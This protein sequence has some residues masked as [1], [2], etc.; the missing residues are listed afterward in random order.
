MEK[1]SKNNS[2]NQ[3]KEMLIKFGELHK[4][5]NN[6]MV[7]LLD[8]KPNIQQII[9]KSS[10]I[11]EFYNLNEEIINLKSKDFPID[12]IGI[13]KKVDTI[14]LQTKLE[15]KFSKYSELITENEI[16]TL[17]YSAIEYLEKQEIDS[18]IKFCTHPIINLLLNIKIFLFKENINSYINMGLKTNTKLIN[19]SAK[20]IYSI[21]NH[22]KEG[23]NKEKL[24]RPLDNLFINNHIIIASKSTAD[25]YIINKI[26]VLNDVLDN[27]GFSKVNIKIESDYA[28]DFRIETGLTHIKIRDYF[29]KLN[30]KNPLNNKV[31]LS[32]T[33]IDILV[34]SNFISKEHPPISKKRLNAN[35]DK[36]TLKRFVYEFYLIHNINFEHKQT[37]YLQFLQDNFTILK[38]ETLTTLS[39]HFARPRNK[40]YFL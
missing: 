37:I 28:D 8:E 35:I 30:V 38:D 5:F 12:E 4:S 21:I 29:M 40:K 7:L 6:Y 9:F 18:G 32:V 36:S 34:N 1:K 31:V 33:D 23:L 15:N 20:L 26:G 39:N 3:I 11:L 17:F 2:E 24:L 22:L 14:L 27:L 25:N 13:L 16:S 10:L 19:D